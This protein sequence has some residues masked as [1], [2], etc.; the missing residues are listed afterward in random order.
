MFAVVVKLTPVA[1]ATGDLSESE[2]MA[3]LSRGTIGTILITD[4]KREGPTVSLSQPPLR[5]RG[6]KSY[7]NQFTVNFTFT[8]NGGQVQ[9]YRASATVT[10][11]F[12][13]AMTPPSVLERIS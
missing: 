10:I 9:T 7:T 5:T 1:I 3:G 2:R 13:G 6:G 12:N 8:P 4:A 11:D